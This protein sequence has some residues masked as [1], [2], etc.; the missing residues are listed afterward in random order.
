M[1]YEPKLPP[2]DTKADKIIKKQQEE[3]K[4]L[5]LYKSKKELLNGKL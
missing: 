5:G 1:I 3:L 4:R 2:K